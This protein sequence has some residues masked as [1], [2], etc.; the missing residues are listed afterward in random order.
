M[1][2]LSIQSV[3]SPPSHNAAFAGT[4]LCSVRHRNCNAPLGLFKDTPRGY[5]FHLGVLSAPEWSGGGGGGGGIE[6][7]SP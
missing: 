7:L 2:L 1:P 4:V 3:V 6:E 5:M